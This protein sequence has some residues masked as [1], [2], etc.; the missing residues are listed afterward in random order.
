MCGGRR[1]SEGQSRGGQSSTSGAGQRRK[2]GSGDASPP[3]DLPQLCRWKTSIP[4]GE[5]PTG[6]PRPGRPYRFMKLLSI[7]D[8]SVSSTLEVND[9]QR[10]I[11]AVTR[12]W[13]RVEQLGCRWSPFA[14]G[15]PPVEGLGEA[16]PAPT[17][18]GQP[19]PAAT[20]PRPEPRWGQAPAVLSPMVHQS[21]PGTPR[22]VRGSGSSLE[23][24]GATG[25]G[26]S[27]CGVWLR[28]LFFPMGSVKSGEWQRALQTHR[29]CGG[30]RVTGLPRRCHCSAVG[31]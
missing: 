1:G 2:A 26:C 9:E 29:Q 4:V 28:F 23:R 14:A 21:P 24:P 22:A 8:S 3:A 15:A 19:L 5:N 25:P 18:P 20:E 12:G 31:I 27:R 6:S 17:L 7:P 11:K 16:L 13:Q 30:D 10:E